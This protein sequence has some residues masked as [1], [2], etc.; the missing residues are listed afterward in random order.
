MTAVCNQPET[1]A[2][3]TQMSPVTAPVV[4]REVL[5]V[6]IDFSCRREIRQ[7]GQTLTGTPTVD[8]LDG[9]GNPS[10]DFTIANIQI[11]STKTQVLFTMTNVGAVPLNTYLFVISCG[12]TAAPPFSS[13]EN[14][15]EGLTVEVEVPAGGLSVGCK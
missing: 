8:V 10:T 7:F 3:K 1:S 14:L 9:S 11:D 13:T 5:N 2:L 4:R 12:I 6:A 15:V